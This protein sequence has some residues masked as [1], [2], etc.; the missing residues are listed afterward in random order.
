MS[1]SFVKECCIVY[2]ESGSVMRMDSELMK[3]AC[4][5]P[6]ERS[7][8]K[9][10]R[11]SASG[12]KVQG[13][14]FNAKP[15]KFA[16]TSGHITQFQSSVKSLDQLR[17][18]DK[19]ELVSFLQSTCGIDFLRKHSLNKKPEV[20]AKKVGKPALLRA[21]EDW[22]ASI[23]SVSADSATSVTSSTVDTGRIQG[24]FEYILSTYVA[25]DTTVVLLHEDYPFELP[26]FGGSPVECQR[27]PSSVLFVFGGVRD[28]HC[29]EERAIIAACKHRGI[30]CVG[31]NLGRTAEFTSK[32]IHAL[33]G[34]NE[35]GV[36]S[37]AVA[38]L[39][40]RC[41]D[42]DTMLKKLKPARKDGSTWDGKRTIKHAVEDSSSTPEPASMS[43]QSQNFGVLLFVDFALSELTT[44]LAQ[45][46]QMYIIVQA[47]VYTLWR[48]RLASERN[49]STSSKEAASSETQDRF[50]PRLSLAFSCGRVLGLDGSLVDIMAARHNAAP[51]E[52]QVLQAVLDLSSRAENVT[53]LDCLDYEASAVQHVLYGSVGV[54]TV[55]V[56][57]GEPSVAGRPSES[58]HATQT[59]GEGGD[60]FRLSEA[61]YRNICGCSCDVPNLDDSESPSPNLLIVARNS[62]GSSN[63]AGETNSLKACLE[64]TKAVYI[65]GDFGLARK[66]RAG[67][68]SSLCLGALVSLV[69]HWHFHARLVPL[70][71]E[72][73]QVSTV[74]DTGRS[75]WEE[76][77]KDKKKSKK[78]K[79]KESK[80]RKQE[81]DKEQ[82]ST[83]C[84]SEIEG[85]HSLSQTNQDTKQKKSKKH[86]KKQRKSDAQ[87]SSH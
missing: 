56:D 20:V 35:A 6:C 9:A 25:D 82:K 74:Q 50:T 11:D 7:L 1:N 51:S 77:R 15:W 42:V 61:A 41:T 67:D 21:C 19:R 29:D 46:E 65:K 14:F 79:E 75:A 33:H 44:D 12:Q 86:K 78:K 10:W 43:I 2:G 81:F 13:C 66:G 3:R 47:C 32:I 57:I 24:A 73:V 26:V 16:S 80:K 45:R 4:K 83:T 62:S 70:L 8:V 36:L 53:L 58:T 87:M 54:R 84:P 85:S 55:V 37:A 52:F 17:E 69:Q 59:H 23:S 40:A 18:L 72:V 76:G 60:Y 38:R 28:V 5:I 63:R 34:H 48:S 30:R 27:V 71:R 22:F 39:G 64:G 49:T 68:T 31:A